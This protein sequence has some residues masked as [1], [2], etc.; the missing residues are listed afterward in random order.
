MAGY[1]IVAAITVDIDAGAAA[2]GGEEV[3]YAEGI[4]T[5]TALNKGWIGTVRGERRRPE[6]ER[7]EAPAVDVE[8]QPLNVCYRVAAKA[9]RNAGTSDSRRTIGGNR[10][11]RHFLEAA[12]DRAPND[13]C[14]RQRAI[15]DAEGAAGSGWQDVADE[16]RS[17]TAII[18]IVAGFAFEI[19]VAAKARNRVVADAA[20]DVIVAGAADDGVIAAVAVGI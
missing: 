13:I 16:I 11:R 9:R 5:D 1:D 15:N 8:F 14:V 7:C 6:V 19:V 18:A 4:G 3:R 10:D 2:G 17:G 12:G 20:D